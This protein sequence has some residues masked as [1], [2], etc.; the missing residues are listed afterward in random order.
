[1]AT[2]NGTYHTDYEKSDGLTDRDILGDKAAVSHDEAS[3][4]G[5]LTEEEKVRAVTDLVVV[6]KSETWF[7]S[8]KLIEPLANIFPPSGN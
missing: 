7:F 8:F 6:A 1:M 5:E 4:I 2:T 3:H